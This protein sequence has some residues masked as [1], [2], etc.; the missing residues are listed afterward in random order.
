MKKLLLT[1]L[2]LFL[3]SL[4]AFSTTLPKSV[5]DYIRSQVKDAVIRFDGLIMFPDK[6]TYLPLIPA[7]EN[8]VDKVSVVYSYPQKSINLNQ[9]PEILVFDNNYVLLKVIKDKNGVTIS[10]DTNYPIT[11]KTGVLP[12]DLLVP[13]GLYIPE[14]L[15]AILGDLKIPVGTQNNT[16]I[17][18][19]EEKLQDEVTEFLDRKN[20]V[21]VPKIDA[22]KNKL[23]F[24]SNYDSNYLRVINSDNTQPMY[25]LKLE[26]IPRSIISAGDGK[27]LL[28]TTG[29]KTFVDVVDVQREEIAKQIDLTIEPSEI[30]TDETNNLAYVAAKDED[31]LFIIDLKNMELKQKVLIKGCPSYMAITPDG[32]KLVYQDKNS[33]RLYVVYPKAEYATRTLTSLPNISK[34]VATN[35][36]V[37]VTSR[38]KNQLEVLSYPTQN[39]SEQIYESPAKLRTIFDTPYR[40]LPAPIE[41]IILAQKTITEKPIDMLYYN[42]K[43]YIL[44]AKQNKI[45]VYDTKSNEIIKTIDLPINGF[46]KKLTRVD[47]T[48]YVVISNAREE[49]YLIFDLDTYSTVQQIPLN[50][51][52]NNLVIVKKSPYTTTPS[53]KETL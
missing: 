2:I 20:P 27:Y 7:V 8:Y 9:K 40:E 6:T 52:I 50:T 32:S 12:Q 45:D 49:K 44:G 35:N 39:A 13:K 1:L 22:L 30:V 41:N 3:G 10:K 51:R 4:E 21:T 42:E 24:I 29:A 46:S 25:S 17:T 11:V 23:Y 36:A 43:L 19:N 47:K 5:T 16:I 53:K 48:N 37:Y 26:S 38:T 18:K 14:S 15:E 28:I 33:A 31:A 34:I